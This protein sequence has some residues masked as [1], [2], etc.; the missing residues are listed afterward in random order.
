MCGGSMEHVQGSQTPVAGPGAICG[1]NNWAGHGCWRAVAAD[2]QRHPGRG[3]EAFAEAARSNFT[4][5]L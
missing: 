1:S 5:E 4:N 2:G 3:Q